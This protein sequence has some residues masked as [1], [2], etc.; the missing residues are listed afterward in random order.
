VRYRVL[1]GAVI[2]T[3]DAPLLGVVSPD[4]GRS[5]P[6]FPWQAWSGRTADQATVETNLNN[7]ADWLRQHGQPLQETLVVGDR[8]MLDAEIALLYDRSGLRH[9]TGLTA[10]TPALKALITAW[11]DAQF[12]A[13]PLED[14]PEPQYWGRGCQVTFTHAGRTAT[15]KGL[16]VVAGPLRDQLRQTRHAELAQLETALAQLRDK[17]GQPRL[18]SVQAV[19]RRV[20]ALLRASKVAPFLAVTVYA[21]SSGQVNLVW[22]RNAT[23]L[24]QAERR[25]GR[26][27]LVTNDW[28]LAQQEMFRLYRQK[29]GVEKCFH[30]SKDDLAISPLYLHQD[31]RIATML[32]VNLLALLAYT[33]LQRQVRQQGL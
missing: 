21:T 33:V 13:F 32:F 25:A 18:R 19:Q 27:L 4:A 30:I 3:S 31:Q 28:S 5:G 20:N 15:H 7:L 24:A 12:A 16:V 8:A 9:L 6:V 23:A 14:G 11:S 29:D 10:A 2:P 22:Q 1:R 17:L 26:Y